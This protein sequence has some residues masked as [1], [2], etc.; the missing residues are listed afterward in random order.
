MR[1]IKRKQKLD[2]VEQRFQKG[3]EIVKDLDAKEFKR[4]IEGLTLAWKGYDCIRRVQT[5]D[6]KE[7]ENADIDKAEEI[8]EKENGKSGKRAK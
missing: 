7:N 6:E 4:V 1:F 2:K 8:L 3:L 5:I